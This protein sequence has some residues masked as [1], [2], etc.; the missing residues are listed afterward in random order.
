MLV[1]IA[2]DFSWWKLCILSLHGNVGMVQLFP[3]GQV[4][5]VI[6][7]EMC[8][9]LSISISVGNMVLPELLG[10][11]KWLHHAMHCQAGQKM[12]GGR[13]LTQC[14]LVSVRYTFKM[15]RLS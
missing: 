11:G 12:P 6:L 2:Q 13:L 10:E 15:S 4:G 3:H 9:L 14:D 5:C 1:D 7:L 8:V